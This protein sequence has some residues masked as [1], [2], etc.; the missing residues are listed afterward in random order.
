VWGDSG[1]LPGDIAI[2]PHASHHF[3]VMGTWTADEDPNLSTQFLL[4]VEENTSGQRIKS[5][6]RAP[7]E[8]V[9]YYKITAD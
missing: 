5:G 8:I 1:I 7:S 6:K 2:I 4:T 9:A 3:I